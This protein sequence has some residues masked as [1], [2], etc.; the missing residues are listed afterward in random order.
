MTVIHPNIYLDSTF[1]GKEEKVIISLEKGLFNSNPATV[2]FLLENKLVNALRE[3]VLL[4]SRPTVVIGIKE[5]PNEQLLT[6]LL[7]K[8]C[9]KC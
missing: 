1:T 3:K 5:L 9:I 6:S 7:Y 4:V 8:G 2:L